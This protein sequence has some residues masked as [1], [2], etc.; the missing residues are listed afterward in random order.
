V[1]VVV[2]NDVDRVRK[3]FTFGGFPDQS[4]DFYGESAAD[5][6]VSY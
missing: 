3:Q 5:S 4:A 1:N 6:L 2:E